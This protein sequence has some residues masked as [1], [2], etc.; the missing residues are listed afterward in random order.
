MTGTVLLAAFIFAFFG[1]FSAL[2]RS[3]WWS[4]Q[5][6][7]PFVSAI[8]AAGITFV[9]MQVCVAVMHGGVQLLLVPGAAAAAMALVLGF[10]GD[11]LVGKLKAKYPQAF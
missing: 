2:S 11:L 7:R 5:G 3:D 6:R 1:T 10:L 8:V 9:L 4:G